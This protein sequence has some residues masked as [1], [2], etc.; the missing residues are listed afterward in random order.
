M[1]AAPRR[2]S[3]RQL[4]VCR[5]LAFIGTAG[6]RFGSTRGASFAPALGL[7]RGTN[8]PPFTRRIS[9][10][11]APTMKRSKRRL[12]IPHYSFVP[13]TFTLIQLC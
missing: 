10:K 6:G 4:P 8:I 1:P 11:G 12:P 7:T 9:R 3:V 5:S 2:D 13:D